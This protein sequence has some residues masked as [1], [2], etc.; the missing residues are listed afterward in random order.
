MMIGNV[1][2]SITRFKVIN[3]SENDIG[4][5]AASMFIPML[6]SIIDINF[7]FNNIGML[8]IKALIRLLKSDNCSLKYINLEKNSLNDKAV[9]MLVEALR[10]YRLAKRLN[11]SQNFLS[12]GSC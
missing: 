10:N 12:F 7:S 11:F 3:L 9:M 6:S 1:V 8:G 4:P 2:D 5:E